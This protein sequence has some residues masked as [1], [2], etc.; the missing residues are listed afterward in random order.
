MGA[1]QRQSMTS[2]NR[3][4]SGGEAPVL[5]SPPSHPFPPQDPSEAVGAQCS[6][7]YLKAAPPASSSQFRI[8]DHH[9][10][11]HSCSVCYPTRG[12]RFGRAIVHQ[13]RRGARAST[14][15]RS[16]FPRRTDLRT[17]AV[18]RHMRRVPMRVRRKGPHLLDIMH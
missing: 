6:E 8:P 12:R 16:P 10:S 7:T 1:N 5:S 3:P 15:V 4:Y 17:R 2:P 9:A 14:D 18:R 13:G 11:P